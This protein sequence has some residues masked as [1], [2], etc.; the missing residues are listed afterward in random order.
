MDGRDVGAGAWDSPPMAQ[1][2][3][4]SLWGRGTTSPALQRGHSINDPLLIPLPLTL[5]PPATPSPSGSHSSASPVPKSSHSATDPGAAETPQPNGARHV[6]WFNSAPSVPRS[7][8]SLLSGS[9][10]C[11]HKE[12]STAATALPSWDLQCPAPSFPRREGLLAFHEVPHART[13][14]LRGLLELG[15]FQV[16]PCP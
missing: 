4:A 14:H 15:I 9:G 6:G 3:S 1:N 10:K 2:P 11:P 8:R 13:S 7:S 16:F 5:R 12:P